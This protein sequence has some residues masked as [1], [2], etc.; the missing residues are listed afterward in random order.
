MNDRDKSEVSGASLKAPGRPGMR[1][2]GGIEFGPAP[3][4]GPMGPGNVLGM[5][6]NGGLG[7]G[8]EPHDERAMMIRAMMRWN[9]ENL[10]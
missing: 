1:S 5:G 2:L 3:V 10:P 7:P 6:P 4:M 9:D 8:I